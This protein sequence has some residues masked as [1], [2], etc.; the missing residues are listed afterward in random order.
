VNAGTDPTVIEIDPD[1]TDPDEFVALTVNVYTP[2]AVGVPDNT[3]LDVFSVN[4]VGNDPD[5]TANVGVGNPDAAKVKLNGIEIVAVDG[6]VSAVNTGPASTAMVIDPDDAPPA[7]LVAPTTN[8]NDPDAP[9][10]PD[11]TPVDGL[12]DNP[13]GRLPKANENVGAGDPVATNV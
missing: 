1:V 11:S 12:S 10:V 5:A 7:A 6:G 3:P 13:V 2:D 9:G 4:P 8:V